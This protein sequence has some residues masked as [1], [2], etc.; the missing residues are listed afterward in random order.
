MPYVDAR[1]KWR[2]KVAVAQSRLVVLCFFFFFLYVGVLLLK[3]DAGLHVCIFPWRVQSA[4]PCVTVSALSEVLKWTVS[5][6]QALISALSGLMHLQGD[7]NIYAANA[8]SS[9]TLT[10]YYM[11]HVH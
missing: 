3:S 6:L 8:D 10:T 7:R 5:L 11:L 9:V 1:E 4:Q 2:E